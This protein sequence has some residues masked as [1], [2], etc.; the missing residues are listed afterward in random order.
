MDDERKVKRDS[1]RVV[2]VVAITI[3]VG[4]GCLLALALAYGMG[5]L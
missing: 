2:D 5:W 4:L 1:E 3:I